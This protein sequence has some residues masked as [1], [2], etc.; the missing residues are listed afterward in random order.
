MQLQEIGA[1][2]ALDSARRDI[3]SRIRRVC[4]HYPEEEFVAL[5]D[6]MARIEVKYRMRDD[7]AFFLEAI[8]RF[9]SARQPLH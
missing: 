5:V 8:E 6:Q 4:L 9:E 7:R 1:G 2:I 3:A